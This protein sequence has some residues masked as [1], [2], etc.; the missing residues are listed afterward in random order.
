MVAIYSN[1]I[2]VSPMNNRKDE[3]L[4]RAYLELL[5][6]AKE[7]GIAVKKHV[8][9]NECSTSMK[10]IIRKECKLELVLPGS[11]RRNMA[12]LAIKAF[13]HHF[14]AILSGVDASFPM[15]MWDKLLPQA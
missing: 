3:E 13:K 8:L 1:G 15:E 12:E 11:H 6:R 14:I 10:E 4:Q 9:D 7:A 5:H 2:L